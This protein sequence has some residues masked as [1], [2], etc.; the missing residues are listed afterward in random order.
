[1]STSPATLLASLSPAASPTAGHIYKVPPVPA[2]VLQAVGRRG[3]AEDPRIA[4]AAFIVAGLVVAAWVAAWYRARRRG[5]RLV[6]AVPRWAQRIVAGTTAFLLVLLGAAVEVNAYV[7]YL[8]DFSS[9]TH[10][11]LP[12]V[13]AAGPPGTPLAPLSNVSQVLR[14]TIGDAGDHMKPS[15]AYVYLPPGYSDPHNADRRY[16]VV[17]LIHGS[18]GRAQDWFRA[19]R[20]PQTADLLIAQH[21]IGPMILVAPTASTNWWADQE[22]LNIPGGPQLENYL[23]FAVPNAIDHRFRTIAGRQGRA[24]G[25]MSSGGYCALNIGLHH[26]HRFGAIL[27]AEPYGDPGRGPYRRLLGHNDALFRVN[28]PTWYLPMWH[29]DPATAVFLDTGTAD[30]ATVGTAEKLAHELTARGEDVG[31][32]LVSGEH[33][34]WRAARLGLPYALEFAWHALAQA[35]P[36]GSDAADA[37]QLAHAFAVAEGGH[38]GDVLRR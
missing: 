4:L 22:C 7:G 33:H 2:R 13:V 38:Y 8:P 1:M 6:P 20:A 18:P 5:G 14:I 21:L 32:R 23:A 34:T 27:S 12:R 31:M 24:I 25:G 37:T 28:S 19:G 17:Y 36:G 30:R 3:W 29:F 16:P 35:K 11:D 10:S 26:L 15:P 9:L